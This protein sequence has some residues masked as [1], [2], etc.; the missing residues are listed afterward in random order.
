MEKPGES[1]YLPMLDI[2]IAITEDGTVERQLYSKA[3]SKG[4]T[5]HYN[6][7]HPST[8]KKAMV[9]NEF[10]RAEQCSTQSNRVAANQATKDKLSQNGYPKKLMRTTHKAGCRKKKS[11]QDKSTNLTLKIPFVSDKL[12]HQIKRILRKHSIPARL[13]SPRGQTIKDLTKP[14]KAKQIKGCKNDECSAKGICHRSSVVYLATCSLCKESYVGTTTRKLHGRV[15]EHLNSAQTRSN[16]TAIG[17]HYRAEHPKG[18]PSDGDLR[19]ALKVKI[20]I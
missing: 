5:L 8:T 11:N 3:T 6:S 12:N 10:R 18:T 1:N 13:V 20:V 17:D 2:K 14:R 4:I 19:R 16:K 15:R 7:H 9:M